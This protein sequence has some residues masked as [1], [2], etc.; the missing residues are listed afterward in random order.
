MLLALL[1]LVLL[2]ILLL[3]VLLWNIAV[4][5]LLVLLPVLL[6]PVLLPVLLVIA[7]EIV[8][9]RVLLPILAIVAPVLAR[10]FSVRKRLVRRVG[11]YGFRFVGLG[12]SLGVGFGTSLGVRDIAVC[13]GS[14]SSSLV[15][16]YCGISSSDA[17]SREDFEYAKSSPLSVPVKISLSGEYESSAS[18]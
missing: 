12:I 1:L 6:L 7:A 15:E 13:V 4:L 16:K 14:R 17:S 9:A 11:Q 10:G 3:A 2:P 8:L 18:T 5:P